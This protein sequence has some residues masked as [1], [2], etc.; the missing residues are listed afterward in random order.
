MVGKRVILLYD[1]EGAKN[2]FTGYKVSVP[3]FLAD[4]AVGRIRR[5]VPEINKG[6]SGK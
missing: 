4:L 2:R 1:E 3:L 5:I 6:T